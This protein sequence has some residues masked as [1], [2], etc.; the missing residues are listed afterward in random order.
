VEGAAPE[1]PM[2]EVERVSKRFGGIQAVNA[3][4]FSVPKGSI[5]GLIGPNG[6]GK[7]TLFNLIVRRLTPDAGRIIFKGIPITNLRPYQIPRAGLSRSFQGVKV[8]RGLKVI[9]NMAIAGMV[10]GGPHWREK[11]RQLLET[12]KLTRLAEEP[13][14]SLSFGQQRLLEIAMS[15][16][17]DPDCLMLDE[18][19]AGVHPNIRDAL[20][21]LIKHLRDSAGKTFLIIEHNIPFVV[22]LCDKLIVLDHGEKIAEGPPDEI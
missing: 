7:S 2:L 21:D 13:A 12:V 3:C 10:R 4:S 8:F 20:T 14:G 6:S 1:R 5:V 22:G 9:D 16:M 19:V 17:P 18:P 11:A 15:L